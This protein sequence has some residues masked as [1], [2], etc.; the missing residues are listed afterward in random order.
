LSDE[1]VPYTPE[2]NGRAERLNRTLLEKRAGHATVLGPGAIVLGRDH[3]DGLCR[4]QL[5]TGH[6]QGEDS[7]RGVFDVKP[8]TARVRLHGVGS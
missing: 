1:S 6:W 7:P 5:L 4:P 3:Y 2:Q 8:N